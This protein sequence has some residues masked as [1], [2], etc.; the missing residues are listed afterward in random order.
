MRLNKFLS[1]TGIA[2]RRAADLLIEQG[3][4]SVNGQVVTKL[5]STID[6][7]SDQVTFDGKPLAIPDDFIYL[8]LNKPIGH[9]VTCNDNYNRPIVLDLIGKYKT[10]VRPVG[11]LDMDSSG[12]LLLTND[13]ELAFRLTHPKFEI[14]KKYLVKCEDSIPDETLDKLRA[15]IELEDGKTSPAEIEVV[16]KNRNFSNFY[17]IIH[18][19][20]KRQIR[21]MCE[22]VGY[23]V[24]ALQRV[25]LGDLEIGALALGSYRLLIETEIAGLRKAVGL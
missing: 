13:G 3:R 23:R 6:E 21:R 16:S 1:K 19:G 4:V 5:G 2:S 7:N 22:A 8:L 20:R 9:L 15:G 24:V 11:R 10:V 17:M 25:A 18:E 12:L 14:D